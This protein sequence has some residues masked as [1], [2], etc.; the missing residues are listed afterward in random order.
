MQWHNHISLQSQTIGLKQ[1]SHLSLRIA[2]TTTRSG[3][4]CPK[5][6]SLLPTFDSLA[7][8]LSPIVQA[9]AF[10]KTESLTV[11]QAG[12]QWYD[13]SSLQP[14]HPRLKR[15]SWLSLPKTGFHYVGQAGLKLVIRPPQPPK[16]LGLQ[17]WNFALLPR[18]EC[19]GAI[20]AYCNLCLLGSRFHHVGQA[21]LELLNTSDP[22]PQGLPNCWNYR[23]L[24]AMVQFWL[25]ATFTY[26]VQAILLPQSLSSWD[27]RN[28]PPHIA[29]CYIF[30]RDRVSPCWPG[31]SQISDLSAKALGYE[32]KD[33]IQSWT[34]AQSLALLPGARLECS[35]A[36]SAHCNLRL[37]GSSNFPAL[38]SQ[39]A[40]TT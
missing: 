18:L 24:S 16:A 33:L 34:I 17:A 2:G 7:W 13:L 11:A 29:N 4:L 9:D 23:R 20:S 32:S 27:Y 5:K 36:I 1:S 25:T 39:V 37:L 19:S 22:L 28:V 12:V 38:A 14:P 35:G 26:Q 40:G 3:T 21:G 15:F 6:K 31:W 10:H 8:V 30:S